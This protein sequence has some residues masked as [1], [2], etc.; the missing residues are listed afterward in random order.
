MHKHAQTF[1]HT[2]TQTHTHMHTQTHSIFAHIKHTYIYPHFTLTYKKY[3]LCMHIG[4]IQ[5]PNY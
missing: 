2:H 1:S 5:K 3:H 4:L